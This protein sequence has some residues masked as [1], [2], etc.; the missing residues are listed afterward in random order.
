[1]IDNIFLIHTLLNFE[2]SNDFYHVQVIQ[3]KKDGC[4]VGKSSAI[5]KT[6]CVHS[7]DDL[8]SK[9]DEIKKLCEAFNAR[10]YI[11]VNKRNHSN[12]GYAVMSNII[13]Q[14]SNGHFNHNG[15]FDS[16]CM[17]APS[18]EKRWLL[19]VDFDG[20]IDEN[21]V[22]S[23]IA[24]V[25]DKLLAAIPTKNG[26]HLIT[27]KFNSLEFDRFVTNSSFKCSVS[28]KKDA[29]MLLYYPNN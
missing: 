6:Y 25:G 13:K 17:S 27:N 8:L 26:Y 4:D 5:L 24:Y 28:V 11:Q 19:D 2:V 20:V 1:M 3:R 16:A 14:I 21:E 12:V 7:T 9:Y 29:Y 18:K 22:D 10:A 15:V 23:I